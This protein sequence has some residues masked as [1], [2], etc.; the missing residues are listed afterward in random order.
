MKIL[1]KMQRRAAIWIL[2]AFKTLPTK[3][4]E[5]IVGIIPI[6]FY[7]QKLASRSQLHPLVLLASHLIRTLMVDLSN[8]PTKPIPHSI[9][10]LTNYQRTIIK[11]HL[12]DSNNKLY[13]VFSSFSPLHPEL[14]PGSR[15]VDNFSDWFSFNLADK[16]KNNKLHFQKLDEMVLQLSSSP[17]MAIIVTDASIKNNITISISH[18]HL[19]DHPLTKMVYHT[20]LVTNTEA[21]LFTIRCSIN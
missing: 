8:S 6:K 21:E 5:A 4:I 12:I 15:I 3:G 18:V 20:A 19:V 7:F 9:N 1:G 14:L 2:G 17:Y 13:R 10:M 11:G 16:G